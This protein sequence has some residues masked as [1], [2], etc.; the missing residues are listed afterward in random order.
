MPTLTGF[1][2]G[3]TVQQKVVATGGSV[4]DSGGF[5]T[6]TFTST[7]SLVVS[8]GGSAEIIVVGG[9]GAGGWGGEASSGY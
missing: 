3:G 6:H 9:G 1:S 2:F 4:S 7:G 8:S 5:R